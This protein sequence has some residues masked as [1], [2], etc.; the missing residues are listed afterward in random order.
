M[1]NINC[2]ICQTAHDVN[3]TCPE[4]GFEV[5][6]LLNPD[7]A[8]LQAYEEQRIEQARTMWNKRVERLATLSAKKPQAFLVTEQLTAY[9]IYE[10]TNS[11][12]SA[13]VN[14]ENEQH[15]KVIAGSCL[16]RPV[17]FT[18]VATPAEK[19]F[20]FTISETGSEESTVFVNNVNVPAVGE[21]PLHDNDDILIKQQDGT[22]RIKFRIN[23]N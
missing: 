17:H 12:G 10:G 15:Q 13:K 14:R 21:T 8:A 22:V 20:L 9:C 18:I 6:V 2:P 23:L 5:H 11:Y 19:R 1:S 16:F 7:N 4:C 3:E